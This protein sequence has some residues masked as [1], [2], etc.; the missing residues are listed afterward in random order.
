M[1]LLTI[2]AFARA[3]RLSPKALRLYDELGLLRPAEVDQ[4]SGYRFYEPAQLERARLVATL[5]R[6]GMPLARILLVCDAGPAEAAAEVAAYWDQVLAQTA[7]RSELAAFLVD[8]LCG[9]AT[10]MSDAHATLGVRFAAGDHI[11]NVRSS[12]ED[13]AY[14]G[15]RVLAVADGLGGH[16]GGERAS[17]AVIDA[18]REL[19]RGDLD[20]DPLAALG[21]AIAETGERLRGMTEADP[22]LE[23]L[24][25][26]VTALLWAGSRLAL[27]HIGD[28]RAYL[29][30]D[31]ELVQLTQDHTY[32]QSLV[33][34]GKL[35][36]EEAAA[37]PRRR[38]LVRALDGV[39]DPQADL[40]LHPVRAGD[41]YLLC[42]DGLHAV[43]PSGELLTS[44]AGAGDPVQAVGDLVGLANAAGG[45]DNIG[46]AVADVIELQ[47]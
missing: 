12:Q 36:A 9:R 2:G 1:G 40:S 33:S 37:H 5:R 20:A 27:V 45:P 31:G 17:Q 42:T 25:T 29:L 41:R 38:L 46:C 3:A 13:R 35:S 6:L 30:R 8:Y 28:S 21:H 43:V 22:S 15:S 23:G 7:A 14:A 19:E 18:L 24:G 26:T 16:P 4:A 34:E 47:L 32:V 10:A 44:L 39:T 11:G